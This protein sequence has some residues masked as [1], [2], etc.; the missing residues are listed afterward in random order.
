M[1]SIRRAE[2]LNTIK[3]NSIVKVK[4]LIESAAC[5]KIT[6]QRDLAYLEQLGMITRSYGIVKCAEP[7]IKDF[8]EV[9]S[10]TNYEEKAAI[11]KLVETLIEDSETVFITHGTTTSNIINY[12]DDDKR[13]I[14]ITDGIDLI[15][16]CRD[17]DNI[18]LMPICGTIN[19]KTRQIES[20]ICIVNEF[21]NINISKLIMG[22]GGITMESGVTF[23]DEI[24]YRLLRDVIEIVDSIIVVADF[25]KFGVKAMTRFLSLDQIDVIVTDSKTDKDLLKSF[26]DAGIKCLV[27][28]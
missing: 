8:Y 10:R 13:P 1:L 14:I 27:A 2:L 28:E 15:D 22:V 9:R 7:E 17:K 16:L 23:Y 6:V 18:R 26:E 19:Y 11:A 25:S 3:S 5:S 20:S 4:D 21:A 24:S 12:L